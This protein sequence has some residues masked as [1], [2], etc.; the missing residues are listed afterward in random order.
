MIFC[1]NYVCE[2]YHK[3]NQIEIVFHFVR[4]LSDSINKKT[5]KILICNIITSL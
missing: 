2:T 4:L 1:V 3:L 5:R